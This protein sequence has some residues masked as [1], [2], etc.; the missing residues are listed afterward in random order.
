MGREMRRVPANWQHP[1][2]PGGGYQPMYDESYREAW[3]KWKEGLAK[4][5]SGQ[6][7]V[8][9]DGVK[10][11]KPLSEIDLSEKTWLSG[12]W[13][14]YSTPPGDSEYY[15]PDWKDEERT[16][17]QMYE[18]TS[19]GTPISPVC[20]S[21]EELARWLADNKASAFGDMTANYE[22]WLATCRRGWAPGAIMEVT[23]SGSKFMSG[24]EAW[25]EGPA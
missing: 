1:R 6:R 2:K 5:E 14:D 11:W 22:D 7:P 3:A 21:V 12:E 4:W 24:V 17:F 20:A 15:R 25:A 9:V 18:D 10:T 23:E 16:H 19:E 8:Y 13:G